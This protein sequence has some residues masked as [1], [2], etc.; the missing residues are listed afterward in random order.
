MDELT[1]LL[2][3]RQLPPETPT[4]IPNPSTKVPQRVKRFNNAQ[5]IQDAYRGG[6]ETNPVLLR[7][8]LGHR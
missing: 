2:L 5:A 1:Q 6:W 4:V 7:L 8:Q 3:N